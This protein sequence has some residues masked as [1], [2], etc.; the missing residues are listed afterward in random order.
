MMLRTLLMRLL[1]SE[2][3]ITLV[4]LITPHIHPECANIVTSFPFPALI[5]ISVHLS[6]NQWPSLDH[7]TYCPSGSSVASLLNIVVIELRVNF[8][9]SM[10]RSWHNTPFQFVT[11]L[12]II[13][14]MISLLLVIFPIVF[15][16]QARGVPTVVPWSYGNGWEK[17]TYVGPSTNA[18]VIDFQSF[19]HPEIISNLFT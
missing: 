8:W 14:P 3:N 12:S 13:G 10:I 9:V 18:N 7:L 5:I 4:S 1:I 17:I 11:I 6:Y 19:S 15:G 2:S 16:E